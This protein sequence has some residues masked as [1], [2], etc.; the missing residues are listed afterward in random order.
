[1][2]AVKISLVTVS[3]NA[4]ATIQRCLDSVFMQNYP[5]LEYIVM[6]GNSDDGTWETIL[7]NVAAIHFFKS[8]PDDGIY[9]AINK[10]IKIA[11]GDIVG[12]LNADDYFVNDGVLNAIAECFEENTPDVVYANLEYVSAR[13]KVVRKWRTGNYERNQFNYGWM[14]PHPTFYARRALFE[15]FGFYREDYGSAADYELM[16]RFMYVHAL[17]VRYLDRVIVRMTTGGVSNRDVRNRLLAW[18][19]D[20]N[21]MK[22][23][24]IR[25]PLL[26]IV[27]KP[28]RKIFQFIC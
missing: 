9:D 3:R 11:T 8:E 14:P 4:V 12:I 22:K 7:K 16:L 25:I 13:G 17:K 6:D 20:F 10:G 28:L 19:F 26:A 24:H 15:E 27:F 1:M 2:C 5:D 21:A 23:N 18:Q